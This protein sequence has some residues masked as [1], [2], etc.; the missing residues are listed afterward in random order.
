MSENQS[1]ENAPGL[2]GRQNDAVAVWTRVAQVPILIGLAIAMILF[3]VS[4]FI[5]IYDSVQAY[6]FMDRNKTI[7][8]I[9]NLLE[10]VFIAQL[11]ILVATN[12]YV[13]YRLNTRQGREAAEADRDKAGRRPIHRI[14]ST[15]IVIASLH[16]LSELLKSAEI[17]G[18]RALIL[19]GFYVA[20]IAAYIATN[21]F[22]QNS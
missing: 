6:E 8:L 10:M 17:S 9:L 11:L 12:A 15:I 14:V 18:E 4:F 13:T 1:Y 3:V 2:G 22:R 16:L 19:I 7:L 20:L 21:V 5:G